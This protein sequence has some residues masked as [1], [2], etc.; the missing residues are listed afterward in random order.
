MGILSDFVVAHAA[1]AEAIAATPKRTRWP[2][3]ESK[4][5]TVIEVAW[6]H[7][8]ITGE[9]ADAPAS[10]P[11]IVRNPFTGR[12]QHVSAF[13]CYA[14]FKCLIDNG[15]S[16]VHEIPASLVDE[17]AGAS[18]LANIAERW[19]ACEEMAG[20]TSSDLVAVLVELQR[21]ALVARK[22]GKALLLWTSL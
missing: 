22:E 10:P 17:L 2:A 11:R 15:E 14:D 4:G 1:E 19:T 7:F 6:L 13:D 12:D 8:L 18:D 3:F 5:F 20:S 21:L 9:E 16:W